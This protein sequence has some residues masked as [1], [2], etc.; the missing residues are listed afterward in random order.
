MRRALISLLVVVLGLTTGCAYTVRGTPVAEQRLDID[1]PFSTDSGNDP[2]SSVDPSESAPPTTSGSGTP[3]TSSSDT[4]ADPVSNLCGLVG[5]GDMPYTGTD[6]A[7]PPTDRDYDPTYDQSCKWQTKSGSLDVGV[8]LRY[9]AGKP[10]ALQ[11]NTGEY[12]L[13]GHKVTYLDRSTDAE[14][15]PSCVLVLDYAAG[16]LG[17]IVIDGSNKYGPICDQGKHLAEV[18]LSKEP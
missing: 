3:P 5:W 12:D 7:G 4:P 18:L 6:K 9:R 2:S 11:Q 1:S 14:V 13:N 10:L 15:Q 16:G 17:I 8:T